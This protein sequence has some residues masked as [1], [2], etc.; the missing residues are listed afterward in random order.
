[1]NKFS[2]Y[3]SRYFA[4]QLTLKRPSNSIESLAPSLAGAKVDLNPHQIDAALFAFN[5]PVSKG[6][7]LADEVGLGKTIEAGI[8]IAQYFAERKRKIL[9]IV[10][11]S[12]RN[13]WLSELDEKFYIKSQILEKKNY[14]QMKKAGMHNPFIQKDHVVICSYQF[15]SNMSKEVSNVA[16]DLVVID[17]AHRLRNVYKPNNVMSNKLKDALKDRRKLLLTATPLQNNLME[18]Y[19]LVSII[20]DKVFGDVKT[21]RE[22]FIK[23]ENE[24]I[25][26][27]NLKARIGQFCKRTLRKQV[28]DYVSYTQRKLILQEYEPSPEEELL[29]NEVSEYLR[30]DELYALPNSQR[31]LMTM[32]LRKLLA[33]SSFAISGTLDS[34]VSR[35]ENMLLEID[36]ELKLDDYDTFE[37]LLEESEL[38][39]DDIKID[40]MK[41]RKK[42]AIELSKLKSYAILAKSITTNAKGENLITALE[43]GFGEDTRTRLGAKR[44]AV[45]FTESRRTQEYIFNLLSEKGFRDDIVLLN[46][47]NTDKGSKDIYK[48]WVIRHKGED[49]VSGSTQADIKAAVVEEFRERASILIG[50]EA[51][52][53]GINLQFCSIIVNYDLPWNPQRIEQRIGRCHRYG[54]KNDVVVVN[55]LNIKNEAD[56]RVHDLLKD[57]FKLFDGLFGSSDEVLGKIEAGMDFENQIAIIYQECKNKDDI[58]IA[59]DELQELHKEKIDQ[60][61]N[62]AKKSILENFD[63]DVAILL[64]ATNL[65]TKKSV[66]QY[67][68][69]LYNFIISEE[70]DKVKP[71]DNTRFFYDGNNH[72]KGYYNLKWK[73]SEEKGEHFLRGE[74]PLCK[75]LINNSKKRL[76]EVSK[77]IFDYKNSGRKISYIDNMNIKTGWFV[78]DK[79]TND[80]LEVQ[81]YLL[82]TALCDDGTLIDSDISGRIIEF[83]IVNS[84]QCII[85]APLNIDIYREQS[86]INTLKVIEKENIKFYIDECKKLDDWSEDL[87]LGLEREL[88][89]VDREISEK[90]KAKNDLVDTISMET[91]IIM[92]AEINKLSKLRT[93]KQ[94]EM[95][96]ERDKI[97]E[98]NL[99]LQ[100]Q[101]QEKVKGKVTVDKIFT[102]QFEII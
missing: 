89:D 90:K 63:E 54:Q 66:T 51:A 72:N 84:F 53:E 12:L 99:V 79:L 44:K 78:L 60:G 36:S 18:L 27:I 41:N 88:L 97:D 75:Q 95:F 40:L 102:V 13:Q 96:D 6:V 1:M 52:A 31:K 23:T 16:W 45:I 68:K 83:P 22:Q 38:I 70:G 71:I 47:S 43:K 69:W 64:K 28:T 46:G 4:E 87:K 91:M 62:G 17:E 74:H 50:T 2:P 49:I 5:S 98:E 25:R 14:N 101:M 86:K 37:E 39:E 29:Y 76:L 65:S 80:A 93:K 8:A 61:L 15:I 26:N 57:K 10:P 42:I 32:I 94:K 33:S 11:A 82:I 67:E 55:F 58:K 21:F 92:Q 19:G 9:L 7:L 59:F 77:V 73:D 24:D 3:G 81:E 34:L 56:R 100:R 30:S 20:D 85:K 35:L 48:S